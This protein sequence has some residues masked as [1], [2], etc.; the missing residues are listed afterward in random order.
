MSELLS[1]PA[2]GKITG[3]T[4]L[5]RQFLAYSWAELSVRAVVNRNVAVLKGASKQGLTGNALTSART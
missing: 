2:T 4:A 1:G 3:K 5:A